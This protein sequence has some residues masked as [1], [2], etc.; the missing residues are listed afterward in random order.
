MDLL[1]AKFID[2]SSHLIVQLLIKFTLL[3][4]ISATDNPETIKMRSE[5]DSE[6]N[7]RTGE[8]AGKPDHVK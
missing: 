6:M 8:D 2:G 7:N 3:G 4:F 5:E 1:A